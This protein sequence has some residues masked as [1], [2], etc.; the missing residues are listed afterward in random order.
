[1]NDSLHKVDNSLV[2][3]I[4]K[5]SYNITQDGNGKIWVNTVGNGLLVIGKDSTH[6]VTELNGLRT[7]DIQSIIAD[8]NGN[9]VATSNEGIDVIDHGDYSIE[10]HGESES[11]SYKEPN[12]N[13]IYKDNSGNIWVGTAQGLIKMLHHESHKYSEVPKV[14]ITQKRLFFNEFDFSK[15]KFKH[16]ENHLSFSYDALWYKAPETVIYR[17]FLEGYDIDWSVETKDRSVTYSNLSDGDYTF[18]VQAKNQNGTWTESEKSVYSFKI[19]PPFWKTLWFIIPM[20][21]LILVLIYLF[22]L[23]RTR[24]L[25]RDKELLEEE[26][27]RRTAEIQKQKEEIEAQRDEIEAQRNYVTEQR[28]KIEDQNKDI[29]ASIMYASRIQKAVLPPL[30]SFEKL[31]G[32]HFIFFKPRDIVSGDFYYLNTKNNQVIV[33]A[34]DCTGHGVPGAFMSILSISLLN[35]IIGEFSG[36][37]DAAIILSRLRDEI[38]KALRQN[39]EDSET[40][41]GLDISLCVIEENKQSL[42]YA[43]AFNPLY[44]IRDNNPVLYKADKMPIGV[45]LRDTESFSNQYIELKKN[46]MLYM[47]SDGFQDQFGGPAKRKYL[48]KK[49]RNFLLSNANKP[50]Q[51]QSELLEEEFCNWRGD[52][53]QIDDVLIIGIKV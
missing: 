15:N 51:I 44:V 50:T 25:Q 12:V 23:F 37:F 34:A 10:F 42:Q 33:A 49:M 48:A 35:K 2:D 8:K 29:T 13:A 28:D 14:L 27:Q 1:M 18:R 53:P 16:D 17:Y 3:S 39:A 30:H 41:D 32:D 43:G 20:G 52:E 45:H 5:I 21:V 40:K 7:N 22:I 46:D 24:K 26:V 9:I 11:V 19:K 31:I 4:G 47:Y 36:Y 6:H 38:K